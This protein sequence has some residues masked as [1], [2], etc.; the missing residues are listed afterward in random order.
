MIA[1]G[2]SN[3]FIVQ[4]VQQQNRLRRLL[5]LQWSYGEDRIVQSCVEHLDIL[6][7]LEKN[8]L[9]WASTLMRRH[10]ELA[11]R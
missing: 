11:S 2:S 4:A 5:N 6:T 9:Q 10:L 7:A 1:A 3:T 8:D